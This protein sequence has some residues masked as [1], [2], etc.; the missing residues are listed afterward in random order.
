MKRLLAMTMAL[1]LT[2]AL[3]AGCGDK[4]AEQESAAETAAAET[5]SAAEESQAAAEQKTYPREA[6]LDG[7]DVDEFVE[8]GE[9]MGV[10]VSVEAPYVSDSQVDSAVQSALDSHPKRTEI[11]DR[12][13]KDG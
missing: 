3:L 12:A 8:P 7:L 11:T 10:E 1:S 13:V 2:A 4:T 9:Y 6:Y 5:E